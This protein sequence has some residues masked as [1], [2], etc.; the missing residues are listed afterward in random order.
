MP[1]YSFIWSKKEL[2]CSTSCRESQERKKSRAFLIQT[3]THKHIPSPTNTHRNTHPPTHQHTDTHTHTEGERG[4]ERENMDE[5]GER[6]K[7]GR[8]KE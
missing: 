3:H 6:A 7:K 4:K 5:H 2:T 1:G 8:R